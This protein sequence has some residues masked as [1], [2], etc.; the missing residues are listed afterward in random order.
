MRA[1]ACPIRIMRARCGVTELWT[2]NH[3]TPCSAP[4]ALYSSPIDLGQ[5]TKTPSA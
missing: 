4:M 2:R 1:H 5:V 3:V